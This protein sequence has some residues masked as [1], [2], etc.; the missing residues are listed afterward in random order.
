MI[1]KYIDHTLLRPD[2]SQKQ[3]E[4][5]CR[6]AAESGFASVCVN[7]CW[8]KLCAGLLLGTGVKVCTVIGFPL[9]AALTEVKALEARLA[10]RDG[11]D[12][13]DMVI[14]IG[15]LKSGNLSMVQQDIASVVAA[16]GGSAVKVIIEACLLSDDEKRTACLLAKKAGAQFVKTSTGL[17]SGGATAY[18]VRLM[19]QTVGE[20]IKIKAAGGI[21]SLSQA[22][23]MIDAGA[24]RIGASC[25]VL[26]LNEERGGGI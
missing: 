10:V 16:A 4:A 1:E 15:A 19:R 25:G 17:S 5:L 22:M 18:D 2:A 21:R 7:P 8:V 23:E 11:A 3:I 14:N 24:N 20:S 12:E 13:I 26:I 6:Q 9:G